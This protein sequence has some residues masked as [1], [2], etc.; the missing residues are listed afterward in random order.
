MQRALF[1]HHSFTICHFDILYVPSA[2]T[3]PSM[4]L[5]RDERVLL[6]CVLFDVDIL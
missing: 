2:I 3:L 6:S 1:N 4:V 5:L